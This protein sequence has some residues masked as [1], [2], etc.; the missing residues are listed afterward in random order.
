MWDW[1]RNWSSRNSETGFSSAFCRE[2]FF[3][4]SLLLLLQS[5][6]NVKNTNGFGFEG[7]VWCQVAHFER[8]ELCEKKNWGVECWKLWGRNKFRN[9]YQRQDAVRTN[10]DIKCDTKTTNRPEMKPI[11]SI[12]HS[13]HNGLSGYEKRVVNLI[14]ILIEWMVSVFHIE[15][16]CVSWT[17]NTIIGQWCGTEGSMFCNSKAKELLSNGF[18]GWIFF[19]K[20]FSANSTNGWFEPKRDRI[21]ISANALALEARTPIGIVSVQNEKSQSTITFKSQ[22]FFSVVAFDSLNIFLGKHTNSVRERERERRKK[23]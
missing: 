22:T 21:S 17:R 11:P 3:Y 7:F 9:V 12:W 20:K 1:W 16:L 13:L 18:F 8:V 15:E 14:S 19:G 6:W 4:Q 5:H 2:G 23:A 10:N